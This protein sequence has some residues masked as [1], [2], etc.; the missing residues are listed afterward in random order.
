MSAIHVEPF[1]SRT[2]EPGDTGNAGP[3]GQT[4]I[5]ARGPG[6]GAMPQNAPG[7]LPLRQG[8]RPT[9]PTGDP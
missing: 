3:C 4:L 7:T 6:S 8:P 1:E 5:A 9:T 2:V